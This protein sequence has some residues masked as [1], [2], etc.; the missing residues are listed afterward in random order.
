MRATALSATPQT[1]CRRDDVLVKCFLLKLWTKKCQ[2]E[3]ETVNWIT[4]NTKPCLK[5]HKP[6][7]K[8]GGCL[9]AILLPVSAGKHLETVNWITINTKPCPKCHK[10]VEKNGGRNLVACIC[11]QT[12]WFLLPVIFVSHM[13]AE[14]N[15]K[16]AYRTKR[17]QTLALLLKREGIVRCLLKQQKRK[18]SYRQGKESLLRGRKRS[19][20]V[21]MV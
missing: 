7:E 9:V 10:P 21:G 8:N 17:L 2:D 14:E 19:T 4:I 1:F 11:G 3:S 15:Y 6:V 5:C 18:A 12:F 13:V 20:F 16:K